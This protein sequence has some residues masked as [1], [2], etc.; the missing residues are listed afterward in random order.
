M[1]IQ[2]Y[3]FFLCFCILL[4]TACTAPI[5]LESPPESDTDATMTG[6]S[7][8]DSKIYK[9]LQRTVDYRGPYSTNNEAPQILISE[10]PSELEIELPLADSTDVLGSIVM[11][12]ADINSTQI[13]LDVKMDPEEIVDIYTQELEADG[14]EKMDA[15]YM[16]GQV[17]TASDSS[18]NASFCSDEQGVMLTAFSEEPETSAVQLTIG[19]I[20]NSPCMMMKMGGMGGMMDR[21]KILPTLDA[22]PNGRITEMGSGGGERSINAS[23]EVQAEQS[24]AEI[25][26]HYSQQLEEQNWALDVSD[27]SELMSF[28]SWN[29]TI[30][31]GDT[32]QKWA[33]T[34]FIATDEVDSANKFVYLRAVQVQE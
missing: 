28:S 1:K 9:L 27:I 10:L 29:T 22:P 13:F 24:I 18:I 20:E 16:M 23:A 2:Q 34:L 4:V 6:H 12:S 25:A 26:A 30:I 21:Y 3:S 33:A 14:F 11:Q 5:L 17:F 31:N 7:D 8:Q 32:E 15:E 19:G